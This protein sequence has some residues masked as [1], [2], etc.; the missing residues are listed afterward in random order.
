MGAKKK[1][2]GT[3]PVGQ[4]GVS[5]YLKNKKSTLKELEAMSEGVN[6]IDQAASVMD[7]EEEESK[8]ITDYIR[9]IFMK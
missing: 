9:S 3:G 8:G 7:R 4:G 2:K 6:P 1:S 5:S